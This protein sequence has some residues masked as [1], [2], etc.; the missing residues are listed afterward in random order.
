MGAMMARTASRTAASFAVGNDVVV[1]LV[2]NVG[3]VSHQ[4]GQNFSDM[5]CL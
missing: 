2:G 1:F 3:V 4:Q 5:S